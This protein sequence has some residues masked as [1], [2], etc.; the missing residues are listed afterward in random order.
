MVAEGRSWPVEVLTLL[1]EE[2]VSLPVE[3]QVSFPG[4]RSRRGAGHLPIAKG[5]S[6]RTKQEAE[7]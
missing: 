1:V 6:R 3:E 4:A 7:R 5:S 2:Q